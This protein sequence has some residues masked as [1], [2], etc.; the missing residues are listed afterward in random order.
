[1]KARF[2][3]PDDSPLIKFAR[4]IGTIEEETEDRVMLVIDLEGHAPWQPSV[5]RI[6]AVKEHIERI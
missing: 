4:L 3:P 1:M 5:A 6:S 2:N